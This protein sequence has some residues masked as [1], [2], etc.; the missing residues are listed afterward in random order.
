MLSKKYK[1][2]IGILDPKMCYACYKEHGKIYEILERPKPK[3]K[4]HPFCRCVIQ[5]MKALKAGTATQ[6]KRDGADFWRH[7]PK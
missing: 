6:K 5:I 7:I 1:N 2:W 4:L 3:P